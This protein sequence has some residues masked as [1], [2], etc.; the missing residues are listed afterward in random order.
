MVN[1]ERDRYEPSAVEEKWQRRWEERARDDSDARSVLRAYLGMR[2]ILWELGVRSSKP[3]TGAP[4][5][6]RAG[7]AKRTGKKPPRV[8]R[9]EVQR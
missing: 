9:V 5:S 4:K 3:R 7:R 8:Q 6:G 1:E 2:E